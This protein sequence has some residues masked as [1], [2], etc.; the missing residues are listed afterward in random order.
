VLDEGRRPGQ[1]DHYE[2]AM[3]PS[4]LSIDARRD[5]PLYKQIFDEI[6]ERIR[7]GLW[8]PGHRL[9]PT[10]DLARQLSTHR[11][12]VVRAYGDLESAGF[13]SSTVG[14]GT[15]VATAAVGPRLVPVR[16]EELSR[17]GPSMPWET[18]LSRAA[19]IEPLARA[20]R[21]ARARP[22]REVVNL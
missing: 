9:P 14:R 21:L 5:E 19:R 12:T 11:N 1:M 10:R 22:S 4:G 20:G 18:L 15:F 13:V 6:A 8:P 7:S 17:V 2:V 16:A 3:V